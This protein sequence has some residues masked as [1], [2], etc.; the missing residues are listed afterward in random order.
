VDFARFSSAVTKMC[1]VGTVLNNPGGGTSTIK[2]IAP[3]TICYVRGKSSISVDLQKLFNAY[4]YFKGKQV[5]CT[6]LK[7]YMPSVFNSKVIQPGHS[8][9]C[10][11]LFLLLEKIGIVQA[12]N[13]LG[14]SC[15]PFYIN[16]PVPNS[17]SWNNGS[18]NHKTGAGLGLR[19]DSQYKPTIFNANFNNIDI[20]HNNQIVAQAVNVS[21]KSCFKL[22]D[23]QIGLWLIHNGHNIW[24]SGTPHRFTITQRSKF[25]IF[26]IF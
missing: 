5:T 13:G 10:T 3:N 11:F 7:K 1:P 26:D 16:V 2:S 6:D 20:Y 25:N 24:P 9:N 15:N 8:C 23:A 18:P 14:K 21:N 22:I 12:I 4:V 19:I 17:S